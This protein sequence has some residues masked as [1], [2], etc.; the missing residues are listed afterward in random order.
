MDMV[1]EKGK[2]CLLKTEGAE[3]PPGKRFR[4]TS[5]CWIFW[6]CRRLKDSFSEADCPIK[7]GDYLDTGLPVV[8]TANGD[9]P[10]YLE[11][12]ASAFFV[13]SR[14]PRPFAEKLRHVMDHL[15]EATL[16]ES[17][18]REVSQQHFDCRQQGARVFFWMQDLLKRER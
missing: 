17:R 7:L 16:V 3:S 12:G 6:P 15:T 5:S 4:S 10:T 18:G 11:D 8:V 2:I 9:I 1:R 14:V 13:D